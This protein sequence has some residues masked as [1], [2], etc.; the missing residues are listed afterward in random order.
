MRS[1]LLLFF[2]YLFYFFFVNVADGIGKDATFDENSHP[3]ICKIKD[4]FKQ[5]EPIYFS[6]IDKSKVSKFKDK[7]HVKKVTGADK[8]S[9]RS[10]KLA[11]PTLLFPMAG[12]I[13]LFVQTLTIP[14]RAKLAEVTPLHKKKWPHV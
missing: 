11:K 4:N 1:L 6:Y 8:I 12:S 13:N 5:I 7:F 14:D 9:G 10:L 3:S 2:F